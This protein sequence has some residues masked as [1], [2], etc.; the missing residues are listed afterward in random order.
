MTALLTT[1]GAETGDAV[2]IIA[3]TV[4]KHV[5]TTLGALPAGGGQPFA[6]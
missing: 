2:L 4:K 6:D 3:D 1:V 5:L